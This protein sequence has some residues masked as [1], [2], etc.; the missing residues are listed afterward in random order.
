MDPSTR[1]QKADEV[2]DL[3]AQPALGDALLS[4]FKYTR[5]Q[6]K[7]AEARSPGLLECYLVQ[8]ENFRLF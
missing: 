4:C 7:D 3:G 8:R 2:R 6:V 1:P 5:E